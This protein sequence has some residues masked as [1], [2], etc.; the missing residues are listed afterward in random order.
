[1]L[2]GTRIRIGIALLTALATAGIAAGC[3]GDN[4]GDNKY[5]LIT[6][7]TLTVGSDIPYPPFE[8]GRAPDYKGIDIDLARAIANELD[9]NLEVKDTAFPTIFRDVAQGKFDMVASSSTITPDRLKE[10]DFSDPYAFAD[11][12]LMVKRGSSIK[13]VDDVAGQTVGAQ[14]ATTGADY[15]KDKTDA[16]SVRTF[17]EIADAFNALEAGQVAAVINDCP[18]SKY[19]EK[20]YPDLQVI[21]ALP[22]GEHYGFA[23]Q[24]G[25]TELEDAVNNALA[26][27]TSNGTYDKIFTTYLARQP[28]RELPGAST[29]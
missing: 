22:T 20:S 25:K 7:G 9:L 15:A 13:N 10:V 1:M 29:G 4:G 28:C 21:E 16:A 27:L 18:I 17:P 11:Q 8:F 26:K 5:G 19:A 24:K 2:R 14:T 12:S 3:G 6:E 23:F